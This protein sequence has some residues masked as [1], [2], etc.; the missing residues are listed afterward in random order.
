MQTKHWAEIAEVGSAWGLSLLYWIYRAFGRW[1]FRILLFPVLAYF[2]LTNSVQRRASAEYLQKI[3]QAGGLKELPGRRLSFRHFQAFAESVLDKLIAWNGGIRLKDVDFSGHEEVAAR[4]ARGEGLLLIGSHLGNIEICRVLSQERD[5]FGL[6]VLV[7]T[8]HAENF[9][10][11]IRR[12]NP[13]AHVSLTQVSDM[14]PGLAAELSY[15]VSQGDCLVIAGDRTPLKRGRVV[16]V[17]FLGEEAEF[18]QGPW[19]L[20]GLLACP[21]YL[22]FCLYINGRYRVFF[23]PFSEGVAL[24]RRG[25]EE[26]IRALAARF[27]TRLEAHCFKAPLQWFNFYP[28]WQKHEQAAR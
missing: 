7:H 12:L 20:A 18:A 5:S 28:F 19:I 6:Q 8:R 23:E 16:R 25:R 1:P 14:H 2:Y 15:R 24:P 10:R 9:N 13:R 3:H 26:A 22:V 11:L 27:A 4:L 17:P 21:V